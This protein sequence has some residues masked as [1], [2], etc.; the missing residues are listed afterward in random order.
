MVAE[1]AS[2]QALVATV[3]LGLS[4]VASAEVFDAAV[5]EDTLRIAVNG[6]LSRLF[7][8]N[9][10]EYSV[11]GVGGD[12]EDF[13]HD[14][15]FAVHGGLLLTGEAGPNLDAGLGARMQ[16]VD[17]ESAEGGA[18]ALGGQVRLKLLQ[19]DRLRFNVSLW[20]GPDASSFGDF[21]EFTEFSASV[22]YEVLR[23]AELYLGYRQI[24]VGIDKGPDVDLEDGAHV[25]I[26]LQF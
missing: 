12:I 14:R 25:G 20:Y 15:F 22:G 10:G 8:V 13:S 26:R 19:A 7:A 18:L 11:G 16:F 23:D 17:A 24:E 21:D 1:R 3:L 5:S 4:C 6:P 9:K 2:L